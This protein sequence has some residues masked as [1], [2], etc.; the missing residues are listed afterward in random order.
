M[1][2]LPL[3]LLVVPGLFAL[4]LGAAEDPSCTSE[5]FCESTGDLDRCRDGEGAGT[6]YRHLAIASDSERCQTYSNSQTESRR[7][8]VVVSG[9]G[10][11]AGVQF[12]RNTSNG[13]ST[14]TC[15]VHASV[16]GLTY[17]QRFDAE[18]CGPASQLLIP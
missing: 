15:F 18:T 12:N 9:T 6:R 1:R 13:E 2:T 16:L 5:T 10:T 11:A 14:D 8:F 7:V 3:M 17:H 4:P